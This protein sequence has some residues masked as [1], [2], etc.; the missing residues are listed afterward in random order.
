MFMLSLKISK[1]KALTALIAV[2]A[3][4]GI[5]LVILSFSNSNNTINSPSGKHSVIVCSNEDK[6]NFLKEFGWK[7]N[8]YS[9]E[10][11]DISIPEIFN[12]TYENYNE[13][14]KNQGFDLSKHKGETCK[15]FVYEVLNYPGKSKGI[16]ATLIISNNRVIAADISS[17]EV[18]G[19][20]EGLDNPNILK[21]AVSN[22]SA[23][24]AVPKENVTKSTERETLAPD[25]KMPRAPTD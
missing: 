25:P 8:E 20:I 12:D 2:L 14:Q 3:L 24:S 17:S 23:S 18:N 4:I 7:I 22:T 15:K 10:V 21:Q 19:F 5:I 11:S 1:K 6:V 16:K 13:I 9:L